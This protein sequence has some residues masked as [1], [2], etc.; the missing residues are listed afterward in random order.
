M[1]TSNAI[2]L[3]KPIVFASLGRSVSNAHKQTSR[4]SNSQCDVDFV[5]T[6]SKIPHAE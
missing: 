1:N 3:E 4:Q 5:F 6:V 2:A